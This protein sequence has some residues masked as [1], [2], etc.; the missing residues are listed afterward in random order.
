MTQRQFDF[1]IG[2]WRVRTG[3]NI[4][5]ENTVTAVAGGCAL[6]EEWRGSDGSTG[7]SLTFL[8]AA[9]GVWHQTWIGN[10]GGTLYL[11]GNFIGDTLQLEGQRSLRNGKRAKERIRWTRLPDGRVRQLWDRQ[12][13]GESEWRVVFDG[14][15]ERAER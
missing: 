10:D 13:E 6:R 2:E 15:Y 8:D 1:W 11:D 12:F 7:T 4:V 14:V 5:G 9:R 3:A